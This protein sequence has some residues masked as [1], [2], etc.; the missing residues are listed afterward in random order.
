MT[1]GIPKRSIFVKVSKIHSELRLTQYASDAIKILHTKPTFDLR[2]LYD[3]HPVEIIHLA[4]GSVPE[5]FGT[6]ETDGAQYTIN[7][8]KLRKGELSKGSTTRKSVVNDQL[9]MVTS[10]LTRPHQSLGQRNQNGSRKDAAFC[11][12]LYDIYMFGRAS[13]KPRYLS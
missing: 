8:G 11:I 7:A 13:C 4:V 12:L 5:H 3:V 10:I 2:R 6:T 9:T 1:E